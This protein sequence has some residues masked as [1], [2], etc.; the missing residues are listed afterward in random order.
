MKVIKPAL[1][2]STVFRLVY[3]YFTD[4]YL[5]VCL[6][7]LQPI[8]RKLILFVYVHGFS[9]SVLRAAGNYFTFFRDYLLCLV[10]PVN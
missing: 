8:S 7:L 3:A 6:F 9:C 10:K 5:Q 1:S 2:I 4:P